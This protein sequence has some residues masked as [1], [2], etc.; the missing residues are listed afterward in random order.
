MYYNNYNSNNDRFKEAQLN[1]FQFFP[2]V[3]AA[4]GLLGEE[5]TR[6]LVWI[7]SVCIIQ[8]SEEDWQKESATMRDV[9][10]NSTC[11]IAAAAS[12]N[13]H[14]GLFR[15]RQ[16]RDIQKSVIW[17]N[18]LGSTSN[19]YHIL[20]KDYWSRQVSDAVLHRRGWVLQERLL[21]PR[22]LHFAKHQVFW[23]CFTDQKCEGFPLGLPKFC[24]TTNFK[25][26]FE[27]QDSS[28]KEVAFSTSLF[29]MW[30][31]IIVSYTNCALTRPS[32]KLVALSGLAQSYQNATGDVYLAGLWRS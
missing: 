31:D 5:P 4:D 12:T 32:D 24:S 10:A 22:T 6:P 3:R 11:N 30:K 16:V 8:D 15:P 19:Y 21:P 29:E 2:S 17:S 28:S 27:L 1:N 7:D 13:T 9:Y 23:E 14:G 18:A 25:P 20:E 26:V